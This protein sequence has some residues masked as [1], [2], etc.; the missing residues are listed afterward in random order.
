[1]LD[2]RIQEEYIERSYFNKLENKLDLFTS[3]VLEYFSNFIVEK[4]NTII[5]TLLNDTHNII[6]CLDIKTKEWEDCDKN[7]LD[8]IQEKYDHNI[9][10]LENNPYKYYGIIKKSTNEFFIKDLTEI[11]RKT[12]GRNCASWNKEMLLTLIIRIDLER[13]GDVKQTNDEILEYMSSTN[14]RRRISE[15]LKLNELTEDALKNMFFWYSQNIDVICLNLRKWF[16]SHD[17]ITFKL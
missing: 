1:M 11:S 6:R 13:I 5:S 15:K 8:D 4:R 3:W 2:L 7:I 17:L 12:E 9:S 14:M 16:E 10:K